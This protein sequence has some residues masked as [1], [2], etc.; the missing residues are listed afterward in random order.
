MLLG[1]SHAASSVGRCMATCYLCGLYKTLSLS[2]E[3]DSSV[4]SCSDP[5]HSIS[6]VLWSL[7]SLIASVSITSGKYGL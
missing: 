2:F 6:D 4:L 1:T 3:N 7:R 5:Y